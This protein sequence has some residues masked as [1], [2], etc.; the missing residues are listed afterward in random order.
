MQRPCSLVSILQR[1]L[2]LQS[3]PNLPAGSISLSLRLSEFAADPAHQTEISASASVVRFL[4][5]NCKILKSN[6]GNHMSL[7][8][9][10][11][12]A[13]KKKKKYKN[14]KIFMRKSQNQFFGILE[15]PY[16]FP[17]SSTQMLQ[18]LQKG[19]GAV[20]GAGDPPAPKHVASASR[21]R[22]L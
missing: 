22:G 14:W 19:S 8:V 9:I 21:Q 13:K 15:K 1:S 10:L 18:D 11:P 12:Y 2:V 6:A 16:H 20:S 4:I 5:K 17:A 3:S 7:R